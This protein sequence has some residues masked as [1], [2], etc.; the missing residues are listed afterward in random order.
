MNK[1][2]ES[3]TFYQTVKLR[4]CSSNGFFLLSGVHMGET[5]SYE[6]PKWT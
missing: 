1:Q 6:K 3:M 5:G 2:G 4:T